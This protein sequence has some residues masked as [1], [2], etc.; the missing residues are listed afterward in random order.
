MI[1]R[2]RATQVLL[3][4]NFTAAEINELFNVIPNVETLRDKFATAAMQNLVGRYDSD[5][6]ESISGLAYKMADEML[7]KRLK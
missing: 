3:D 1:N 2:K 4:A 7:A 6:Y 5:N